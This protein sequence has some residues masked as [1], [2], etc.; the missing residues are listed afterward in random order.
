MGFNWLKA[1]ATSRR[2]FTWESFIL[3]KQTVDKNQALVLI[4]IFREKNP[5]KK[6]GLIYDLL[7]EKGPIV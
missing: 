6:R 4:S 7:R 2:Q 5:Y 1:T 3:K